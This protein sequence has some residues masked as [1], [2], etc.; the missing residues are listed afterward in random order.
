ML[1][2]LLRF[3]IGKRKVTVLPGGPRLL[4]RARFLNH[5]LET[6]YRHPLG[7]PAKGQSHADRN[8]RSQLPGWRS[9]GRPASVNRSQTAR[10]TDRLSVPGGKPPEATP[11][12][13]PPGRQIWSRCS[14]V[15]PQ[16]RDSPD[17]FAHRFHARRRVRLTNRPSA[18]GQVAP[19]RV[20]YS[21]RRICPGAN[22]RAARKSEPSARS[23]AAFGGRRLGGTRASRR[24]GLPRCCWQRL[25]L[26]PGQQCPPRTSA[27]AG[28]PG[29]PSTG[30][31]RS[32]VSPWPGSPAMSGA[33]DI[34]PEPAG[35]A[36]HCRQS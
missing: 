23:P 24:R 13:V 30:D 1:H 6:I 21:L 33:E 26:C 5:S 9:L 35:G 19:A 34:A 12:G 36:T 31:W 27:A 15:Q 17:T 14:H 29:R 16:A 25:N 3:D 20:R 7:R 11:P 8:R 28:R 4:Q 32:A 18:V 22:R 2:L 10:R